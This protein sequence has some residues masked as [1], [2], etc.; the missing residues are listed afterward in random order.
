TTVISGATTSTYKPVTA[1]V[2][3]TVTV[4]V[5]GTKTG[6]TTTSKTSAPT[7]EITAELH[8]KGTL[9]SN[10]TWDATNTPVVVIDDDLSIPNGITL[11]IQGGVVI[12]SYGAGIQVSGSLLANG[13]ATSPVTFTSLRDDTI[14]GDSNGD[15][16][17]T[18]PSAGDWQ[19]I[20]VIDA[21]SLVSTYGNIRYAS[22]AVNAN[23]GAKTVEVSNA[24]ISNSGST[25]IDVWVDRSGANA[26]T[27]S[28]KIQNNIV[29]NSAGMGIFVRATGQPEGSGTQIPI[30]TVQNNTVTG[31]G[32]TAIHIFGDKLDGALLRGNGGSSNT[33]NGISVSGKLTTNAS[34]PLGGLPLI[35]DDGTYWAD[36][37]TIA[38][39]ATLT[40]SA[41]QVIKSYG[42]GIQVSGS[43]PA[44]GTATSPVTFTSLRDDT[45]GGDGNGDGDVTVP[46]AGDWQ[47]ID[48]IDAGQAH[49]IGTDI[50]YA[51]T[52]LYV[53]SGAGAELHGWV[54]FT[55]AGVQADG[56]ADVTNTD[57]GGDPTGPAPLGG[58]PAVTGAGA[59]I[60]PWVGYVAPVRKTPTAHATLPVYYDC[61]SI[62][63]IGARGSG[64]V[65]QYSFDYSDNAVETEEDFFG[66]YVQEIYNSYAAL[67]S[68]SVKPLGLR[69]AAVPT[70]GNYSPL[71]QG[72]VS[73]TSFADSVYDGAD[74]L[75]DLLDQESRRCPREKFILSG[76]SQGGIVIHEFLRMHG[77]DTALMDK[78]IGVAL[79]A[80]GSRV[81]F[82]AEDKY[83]GLNTTETAQP[84]PGI[85]ASILSGN[86][87]GAPPIPN[88]LAQRTV[89]ICHHFDMVCG[90]TFMAN[91]F[92]HTNYS[93]PELQFVAEKLYSK[94]T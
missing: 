90:V 82:G 5:T 75:Y 41:G 77:G 84:Y 48:V 56:Y 53:A 61:K 38:S 45:I 80:D 15:G 23:A 18:V 71:L 65:P 37:L 59:V 28:V 13:T 91:I 68:R 47:G 70:P 29:R 4:T 2:G 14:G 7:A 88:T 42:A 81:S 86:A 46:S 11:Q 31:S 16:D 76:Y 39:N 1:D 21:G 85:W 63:F 94:T 93:E 54:R 79:V 67:D 64:Q 22:T 57:W 24:T 9:S 10:Q 43:L 69:Y 66:D 62:A 89:S 12:K 87:G 6:Y 35:I 55:T 27:A 32:S 83:A 20:D 33:I 44:N 49:L 25:G 73:P 52:A 36:A 19:G 51:S 3:A 40:I 92:Q 58:G 74:L 17:V 50:R 78:I 8:V 34:V 30:P 26:G 60:V 72:F